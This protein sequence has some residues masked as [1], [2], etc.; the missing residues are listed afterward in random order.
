MHFLGGFWVGISFLWIYF[1]SGLFNTLTF[2]RKKTFWS[3]IIVFIIVAL[4]WEVFE[5]FIHHTN[6]EPNFISDTLGDIILGMF[7]AIVAYRYFVSN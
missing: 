4:S 5:V 6:K 1:F 2:T 7:G 3:V